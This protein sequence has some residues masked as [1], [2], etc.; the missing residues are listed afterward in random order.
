MGEDTNV[1]VGE[2]FPR[3]IP[4]QA[5]DRLIPDITSRGLMFLLLVMSEENEEFTALKRKSLMIGLD[6]RRSVLM[7]SMEAEDKLAVAGYF[8]PFIYHPDHVGSYIEEHGSLWQFV[9]LDSSKTV[10]VTRME[11]IDDEVVEYGRNG[12][13]MTLDNYSGFQEVD[14]IARDVL[15]KTRSVRQMVFD[16]KQK[17]LCML[18]STIN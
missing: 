10:R 11:H 8:N 1:T 2:T 15:E 5:R 16:S 3:R 7:L 17:Q 18:G 9:A 4:S 12:M 14:D 6:I 13:R